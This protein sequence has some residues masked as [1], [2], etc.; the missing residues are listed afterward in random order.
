VQPLVLQHISREDVMMIRATAIA[1]AAGACLSHVAV[2]QTTLYSN[3][4][5][6]GVRGPEW[7]TNTTIIHHQNFTRFVGRYSQ[8]ESV[9]LTL[10]APQVPSGGGSGGS[11]GSTGGSSGGST[12]GP[13]GGDSTLYNTF[14]LSFDLYV[15]DSW[16]GDL[17]PHGPD[18]FQI[19]VNGIKHYDHTFANQ[20]QYQSFRAPDIGPAHM[21]FNGLYM[22]SIYRQIAVPFEIGSAETISIKFRS[23][24]LL[25][26]DDESWGIDN[27]RVTYTTVPSPGSLCLLGAGLAILVP[28][29]RRPA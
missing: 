19:W 17:T 9:T 18:A 26:L 14:L 21:G 10:T 15:L 28:R 23:Q 2:A 3:D 24:G 11:G 7:S 8:N 6:S 25:H 1:F 27:V 13:A 29:R 12:G 5:E 4:F 20:H 22:D 16:D